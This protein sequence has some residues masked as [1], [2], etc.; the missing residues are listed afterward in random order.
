MTKLLAHSGVTEDAL[1]EFKKLGDLVV[2]PME[3]EERI[4]E[5]IKDVDA[6]IIR[7]KPHVTKKCIEAAKNLKV[8]GRGGVAISNID[9]DAQDLCKERGINIVT[10]PEATTISVAEMAFSLIFSLLRNVPQGDAS[11]RRGEWERKKFMGNELNGKSWGILGFGRIGRAVAERLSD[12]GVNLY[13]H[14]PYCNKEI[15]SGYGALKIDDFDE[16]LSKCDIISIHCALVPETKHLLNKESLAKLP[17]GAYVINLARGAIVDTKA[18][19][20]ALKSGKLSGAALDVYEQEPPEDKE[21]LELDN[22]V[23]TPH[24]GAS[25]VEAQERATSTLFEKLKEELK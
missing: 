5:L 4:C 14:D 6:L 25:T 24:L 2:D 17:D 3:T 19:I 22:I 23:I 10:T 18:L 9:Q 20:E 21:L 13:A 16:F 12:F 8:I 1:N 7:S 11:M 15:C